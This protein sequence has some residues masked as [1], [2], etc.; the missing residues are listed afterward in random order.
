LFG[1][2]DRELS[3][4]DSLPE[5]DID[6]VELNAYL[7]LAYGHFVAEHLPSDQQKR[8]SGALAIVRAD[9]TARIGLS[10]TGDP[11][12]P[13]RLRTLS[14]S[15]ALMPLLGVAMTNPVAP[16]DTAITPVARR[17]ALHDLVVW[18]GFSSG[19]GRSLQRALTGASTAIAPRWGDRMRVRRR[20]PRSPERLDAVELTAIRLVAAELARQREGLDS[21]PWVYATLARAESELRRDHTR[22][23]PYSDPRGPTLR[24]LDLRVRALTRAIR[25][26]DRRGLAPSTRPPTD[27][28]RGRSV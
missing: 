17:D 2:L 21:D 28:Q 11:P 1:S 14:K 8:F 4:P 24:L 6:D 27:P 18:I 20:W 5:P 7:L 9:L 13:A 12:D 3:V 19:Y 25:T 10:D 22:L 15:T 16:Y 23:S 26:L